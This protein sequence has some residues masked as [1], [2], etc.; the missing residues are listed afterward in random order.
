MFFHD[1]STSYRFPM[2]SIYSE[3]TSILYFWLLKQNDRLL[4]ESYKGLSIIRLKII[5]LL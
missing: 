4:Q 3:S 2:L 1:K 5:D